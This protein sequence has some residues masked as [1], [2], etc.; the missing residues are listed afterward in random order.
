MKIVLI[1]IMATTF[2]TNAV[3]QESSKFLVGLKGG[4]NFSSVYNPQ[5]DEFKADPK[6]GLAAGAFA[7]MPIGRYAGIQSEFLFSQKRFGVSGKVLGA[8]YQLIRTASY[9]DI[10]IFFTV[11]PTEFLTLLAGPQYSYLLHEKNVFK[12]TVLT[13]E[14]EQIFKDDNVRKSVLCF[15]GGGDINVD[16]LVL[17][18]RVGWDILNNSKDE[19]DLTTHYKKVWYQI[20][21]GYRFYN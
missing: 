21:L 9:I 18:I 15:T 1:A 6:F 20:M 11:A 16:H 7:G 19:S 17:G 14:Q 4:T 8:P 10:P 2:I 3:A 12:N 5:G 13:G